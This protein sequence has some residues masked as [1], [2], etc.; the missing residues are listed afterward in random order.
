MDVV[1]SFLQETC[2]VI[3]NSN[4][5]EKGRFVTEPSFIST[6]GKLLK[7]QDT[8][9]RRNS[10]TIIRLLSTGSASRSGRIMNEGIG[11]SLS[12]NAV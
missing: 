2:H 8:A 11:K 9:I 3:E 10:S 6:I 5:N 12:W 4:E 7:V 1:E